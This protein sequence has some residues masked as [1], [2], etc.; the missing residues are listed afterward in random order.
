MIVSTTTYCVFGNNPYHSGLN[1]EATPLAFVTDGE[2]LVAALQLVTK[3]LITADL[4]IHNPG[5]QEA[6]CAIPRNPEAS[7]CAK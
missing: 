7:D 3:G 4:T 5:V 6:C 1:P 2:I